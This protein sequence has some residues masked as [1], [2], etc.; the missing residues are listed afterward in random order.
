MTAEQQEYILIERHSQPGKNGVTM[1]RLVFYSL[2]TGEVCEMTVDS[3][4][5]NFR[6][7]GWEHVVQD[8]C[9]WGAY[10]DLRRTSRRTA[11]DRPVLTADSPARIVWRSESNDQAWQ[12]VEADQRQ[13]NPTDFERLFA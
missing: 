2:A 12:L 8:P 5:R 4:Y 1:W 9:P 10:I 6:R 13:R 11:Q 3:T 7:S